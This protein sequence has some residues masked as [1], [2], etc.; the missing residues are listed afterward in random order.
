MHKQL[1]ALLACPS[2]RG[3]LE[4][5]C[6]EEQAG[7]IE[8]AALTC[9]AC[10]LVVPVCHGFALFAEARP[11]PARP[12]AA[13]LAE[14]SGR[15]FGS[16]ADYRRFVAQKA[17]RGVT[18]SYAAFQPFNESSRAIYPLLPL[19]REVLRPGDVIL[20]T[21][22]RTGWSGEL[23]AGLFPAQRVVSI[24]EGDGNVLGYRGFRHW[25]GSGRRAPNLD[26]LF[27]HPD[28]PLPLH[29][30]RIAL[31]HGLDSLHRYR[32]G[33]FIPETLRVCRPDGVLLFP[34]VHLSNGRPEPF[35]E[36]GGRQ[37]H[38]REWKAWLDRLLAGSPRSAWVLPE[39]ELF[40]MA[41]PRPLRDDSQ[42]AHYNGLIL[43]GPRAFEGAELLPQP[44]LPLGGG[45]RFVRNPL[46]DIAPDQ[47]RVRR[48]GEEL[49]GLGGE[50]LARH[51]CYAQRLAEH[52]GER[53]DAQEARFL[54]HAGEALTLDEIAAAMGLPQQAALALA[55][56]LCQRELLHGA[57]VS[58]AM[59]WLQHFHGFSHFAEAPPDCFATIWQALDA[60]FA[61]QTLMRWLQDGSELSVDDAAWLVN[62]IR[63][64]LQDQGL[65]A[66]ERV[67]LVVR[68]HPEALLLCWACWLSGIAVVPL[69][70]GLPPWQ[71]RKIL[72]DTGAALLFTDHPPPAEWG[73]LPRVLFDGADARHAPGPSFGDWLEGALDQPPPAVHASPAAEAVILYTSGS[74]GEAKGVV[75][76]Q[77]ALCASGHNMATTHRWDGDT[78][79]SLGGLGMM[80]GLRNPAVAA[81]ISG[82]R[83]LVPGAATL[84][85]PLA[86]W[87]QAV[88]NRAG[89]ITAVPAW[90][91]MLLAH[92]GVRPAPG[93][94]QI[95]LSGAPLGA[96]LRARAVRQ[97]ACG[98]GDYYGL[99]ESGGLCAAVLP[100]EPEAGGT[101]GRAAGAL[102]QIVGPDEQAV[103][104]GEAGLLRVCSAQLMSGYLDRPAQTAR[105]L[106]EGWLH[107]GD[108]CCWDAQGRLVLLGR[109]DDL[110]KLRS[111]AAFQPA[112][113][114]SVLAA[115]PGV[116]DAAIT[117]AGRA[118][119]LV[120][121]LVT[122]REPA[123]IRAEVLAGYAD[124]LAASELPER[125][126]GVAGLPRSA[127]GKL[128]RQALAAQAERELAAAD[129]QA[130][131][132]RCPLN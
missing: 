99:T 88:N 59:A 60:R 55:E 69:D 13:W 101:L 38:G 22:C 25:L 28:H 116:R 123:A 12:L 75:L 11:H 124:Q 15:L 112:R 37:Y 24:W 113:L 81:L 84:R 1:A 85:H 7:E 104:D 46:L 23:L 78:L 40:G 63:R 47:C 89:I 39:V 29:G 44:Q 79:L 6:L 20:D 18:D 94:K 2:C 111:G 19:L 80:S 107:T 92:P 103:D 114:E 128:Q 127:N 131:N 97:L 9:P 118:S 122:D 72:A 83:I 106:R 3:D 98:V 42:T 32:H 109:D 121:L 56:R 70:P 132:G 4:V 129:E 130:E 71:I 64:R 66:G 105:V 8:L 95:L 68:H 33:S 54:W 86:A 49:G 108:R 30:G 76:S 61:D 67:A 16:T 125:W 117:L 43:I 58:R 21:W 90:L 82:T 51:P 93:L 100:G 34:H 26:I 41:Q 17:L 119:R 74:T 31:V 50:L 57:P 53:L 65:A 102:L 77:R 45:S 36:R 62:G 96:E 73:E 48:T 87:E 35:F 27:T 126:I 52:A 110:L 5:D 120:A 10:Q 91:Q 14:L 115:L